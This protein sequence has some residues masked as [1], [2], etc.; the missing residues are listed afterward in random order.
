MQTTEIKTAFTDAAARTWNLAPITYLDAKRVKHETGTDLYELTRSGIDRL[1]ALLADP[2]SLVSVVYALL[3]PKIDKL[4]IT[5]EQFAES[6]GQPE[7]LEQI[8]NAFV[9]AYIGFFP[10]SATRETLRRVVDKSKEVTDAMNKRIQT[11]IDAI[12]LE[13]IMKPSKPSVVDS[14]GSP[15]LTPTRSPSES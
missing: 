9:E 3:K 14:P 12:N 13:S 4:A 6:I 1:A 8:G 5:E 2:F 10:Q 7:T 15:E 11:Q